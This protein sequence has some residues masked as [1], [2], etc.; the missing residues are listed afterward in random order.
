MPKFIHVQ[1]NI[2]C[3]CTI[4]FKLINLLSVVNFVIYLASFVKVFR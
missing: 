3:K 2:S 4:F 1:I